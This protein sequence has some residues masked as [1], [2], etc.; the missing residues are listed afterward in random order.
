[1]KK[2]PLLLFFVI[3]LIVSAIVLLEKQKTPKS[4]LSSRGI[5][6]SGAKDKAAK[7]RIDLKEKKFQ[8]AQELIFSRDVINSRPFALKD[9]IGK[10]VIL[11]DFWTY[12]CINCQRTLPYL[13]AWDERYRN[14]G[15]LIIG[16]HSPEFNFEKEYASVADAVK[17]AGLRYPVVL[18]NEHA[19][20]ELYNTIY[21]PTEF[22]ID[23]D[24]FIVEKHIGDGDYEETE[25]KIQELLE[26]RRRVLSGERMLPDRTVSRP[27]AAVTV[28]FS[29]IGTPEIYLGSQKTRGHFG[30][31]EGLVYAK[32]IDYRLP[33]NISP[34]MVYVDGSWYNDAD[35][36]T[37]KS[38]N[39]KIVLIYKAKVVNMVMG[40]SQGSIRLRI[41]LD[42]KLLTEKNRGRD[43]SAENIV[44][45]SSF[46]LYNIISDSRY[47]Q[48]RLEIEVQDAG[49][50]V[51]AFTFG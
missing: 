21:W 5:F 49:L 30:N 34:H 37:L 8:R 50:E 25:H 36:L 2:R 35:A 6:V 29:E 31:A 7:G 12:S 41:K 44:S 10:K 48:H 20:L 15:L 42:G 19:N 46:E 24:G 11:L 38:K 43:I 40:A 26:E 14:D 27:L 39:G 9:F 16:I 51:Y 33:K 28:D 47:G 22:L 1:M 18:D 45:V 23:I 4:L 3:F 13:E 32:T 17:K